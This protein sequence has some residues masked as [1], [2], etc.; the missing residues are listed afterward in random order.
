MKHKMFSFAQTQDV[1]QRL[2]FV[3]GNVEFSWK[4]VSV[5]AIAGVD[6]VA[7]AGTI[8]LSKGELSTSIDISIID[9]DNPELNKTFRVELYD[10]KLGGT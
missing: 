7:D 1:L 2:N 8:V 3:V 5:T 10:G 9:N 4:T 6:Y